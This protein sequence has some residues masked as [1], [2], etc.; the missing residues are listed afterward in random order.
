MDKMSREGGVELL[1]YLSCALFFSL[2]FKE[3][4]SLFWSPSI[5]VVALVLVLLNINNMRLSPKVFEYL[6]ACMVFISLG[7]FYYVFPL[8]PDNIRVDDPLAFFDSQKYALSAQMKIEEGAGLGH[9]LSIGIER[10]IIVIYRIFGINEVNVVAINSLVFIAS[11]TVFSNII[12]P[13]GKTRY[14]VASFMA[15][16]PLTFFYAIQPS[17]EILS[18]ALVAAFIGLM[19]SKT[20]T[21]PAKKF[22]LYSLFFL[23]A[24]F[25][26]LNLAIFL[27]IFLLVSQL[28]FNRRLFFQFAFIAIIASISI[29]VVN[30]FSIE[31]MGVGVDF[32]LDKMQSTLD[33]SLRLQEATK[34]NHSTDSV[35]SV[36][37]MFLSPDSTLLSIIF[38]P[39]KMVIVWIS[40]FPIFKGVFPL[41]L[42]GAESS[43]YVLNLL[44]ALSAVLNFLL[45]PAI[46]MMFIRFNGLND[47]SKLVLVFV[48]TYLAMVAF[49]YPTQFTRHRVL[50]E[51]PMYMLFIQ[52]FGLW[53]PL[54][55]KFVYIMAT[56]GFA[57]IFL[58]MLSVVV[59]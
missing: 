51:I 5:L 28:R 12:S 29:Y 16:V 27:I 4:N 43:I 36:I 54:Y 45:L 47:S 8:G 1:S 10:Y 37:K 49:V 13:H 7:C 42:T 46:F 17:K 24:M 3:E 57:V 50:I 44:T 15:L 48:V 11:V 32:W 33:P 56:M 31:V 19:T 58:V 40:P 23:V 18:V 9:W 20:L 6:K 21:N 39:I 55:L 59:L 30:L 52:Y 2:F 25:V 53:L 22:V 38:I 34:K 41:P 26:R 14:S 35:S